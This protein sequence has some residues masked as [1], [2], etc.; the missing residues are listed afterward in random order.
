[1]GD[2]TTTIFLNIFILNFIFSLTFFLIKK[3]Q[4]I[5]A[6]DQPPFTPQKLCRMA[7]RSLSPKP[8]A[9]LLMYAV[10]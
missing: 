1:M 5:K 4:K 2:Y 7:V 9:P 3:L 6:K 10:V 8:A